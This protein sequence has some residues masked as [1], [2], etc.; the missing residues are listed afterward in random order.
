M[1]GRSFPIT[2]GLL[3][4]PTIILLVVRTSLPVVDSILVSDRNTLIGIHVFAALIGLILAGR[5]VK[6]RDH[7]F[8]RSGAI[9]R[10]SRTYELEDGGLWSRADE[11]L[12][13]LERRNSKKK[14]I[15]MSGGV[16]SINAESREIDLGDEEPGDIR[17]SGVEVSTDAG[18][19]QN[20]SES[21]MK[22]PIP[23]KSIG[24]SS[25][26]DKRAEKVARKRLEKIRS[27]QSENSVV[28]TLSC[29]SCGSTSPYGTSYCTTCGSLL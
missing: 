16:A 11:A 27:K 18:D 3:L 23:R 22:S 6:N 15:Q 2:F 14:P 25:W 29:K 17:V 5:G 8:L 28:T 24:I 20:L 1:A 13:R 26:L 9:D 4:T 12:A 21:V 19:E 10:L 7:E